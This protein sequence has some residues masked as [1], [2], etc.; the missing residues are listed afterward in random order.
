MLGYLWFLGNDRRVP[1]AIR[2]QMQSLGLARDEYADNVNWPY[3]LDM[4]ETRRMVA[5]A[6][7]TELHRRGEAVVRDAVGLAST[8]PVDF[9]M[10]QRFVDA[11]GHVANEGGFQVPFQSAVPISYLAIV[12]RKEQCVSL[13]VPV[14]IS[15]SHVGYN[16]AGQDGPDGAGPIGRRGSV[17]GHRA[18][19]GRPGPA[20]SDLGGTV[21]QGWAAILKVV[22]K[23]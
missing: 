7:V 16:A 18:G 10:V 9:A 5:E 8:K 1:E 19:A 15:A 12:P 3:L 2:A 6:M 13:L 23:L 21:G 11:S 17:P 14:C 20:V 22:A 4:G